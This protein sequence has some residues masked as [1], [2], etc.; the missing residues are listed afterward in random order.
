MSL[1]GLLH[2]SRCHPTGWLGHSK[3]CILV[4]KH[5]LL[6]WSFLLHPDCFLVGVD[7]V[8]TQQDF[9][10]VSHFVVASSPRLAGS[11]AQGPQ[12]FPQAGLPLMLM[13]FPDI[14]ECW[15]IPTICA[16]ASASTKSGASSVSAPQVSATTVSCCSAKVPPPPL[17]SPP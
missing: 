17:A 12:M 7:I 9:S 5:S 3:H 16:G 10:H 8:W 6:L 13:Y 15:Q 14:G 1:R 2:S 4:E 11:L